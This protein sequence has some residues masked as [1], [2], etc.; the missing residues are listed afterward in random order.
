MSIGHRGSR[1]LR[2]SVPCLTAASSALLASLVGPARATP[3]QAAVPQPLF[4]SHDVLLLRLAAD[5]H[6]VTRDVGDDREEHFAKLSY[7]DSDGDSVFLQVTV[8]ARGRFRRNRRICNFPPLKL[9]LRKPEFPKDQLRGTLFEN[10]N[11]LKLVCHCQD[12]R[13][14]Y[15][16]LVLK[17]YLA[18]R[19]YALFTDASF[20]VRLA[21]IT[22]VDTSERRDSLTRYAFFVED[23]DRLAARNGARI[24]DSLGIRQDETDEQQRALFAFFQYFIG[25]TDWKVSA[26]HNVILLSRG[27]D[28]PLPVPYDFD[29]AGAVDP[30]YAAPPPELGTYDVRQRV[31]ISPCL[32]DYDIARVISLFAERKDEI[33]SLYANTVGLDERSRRRSF[34]YFESFYETVNDPRAVAREFVRSCPRG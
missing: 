27:G 33:F 2:V 18:Y 9:D 20:R 32:A 31:F 3:Q 7:R 34:D 21:R 17:E 29:W 26:Q 14:E 16:Q 19:V 28:L 15:E 13:E 1:L 24:L 23:E 10:Q 5:F 22:Y 6:T 12:G 8:Q 11:E 25:N 30:P 4:E